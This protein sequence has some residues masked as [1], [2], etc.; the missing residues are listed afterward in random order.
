M[1]GLYSLP[2]Q[3]KKYHTVDSRVQQAGAM[4]DKNLAL[5]AATITGS[6]TN[7]E[8]KARAIFY[9]I[10]NNI[11]LDPK[12]IKTNDQKNSDPVKVIELRKATS[13][14]FS[15]LFQEMCS[16]ANIRCLSVDGYVKD[17]PEAINDI[18]DE[19]NHSWNVVQLGQSPEEW[20][21]VDAAKASGYLDK[22]FSMFT[23]K[24]TSGYF[25]ADKILFNLD[26]YPD[27]KAWQLEDGANSL[28]EFYA[29]PVIAANAY[30]LGLQ[31]PK[32]ATGFL[33]IKT[34]TTISF[35]IPYNGSQV[36]TV[37]LVTGQ[38]K[39]LNKPIPVNFKTTDYTISFNYTFKTEA[40]FP[41]RIFIDGKQVL[42]YLLEV[43]E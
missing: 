18:P 39:K 36:D 15:L 1:A 13:L 21:Y 3:Q 11:A 41:L 22:K 10:A 27:N 19:M 33:R 40:E 9:W 31:K 32:P 34:N 17:F 16:Q 26:H 29:L 43:N 35:S 8:D 37:T 23:K 14:G 4:A 7:K 6:F 5:I 28:K 42:S 24:F 12:G 30:D 25:F 38:E 20:Y 2:A